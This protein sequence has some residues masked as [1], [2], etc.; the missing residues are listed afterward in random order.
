MY[1]M[2]LSAY[3]KVKLVD[4]TQPLIDHFFLICMYTTNFWIWYKSYRYWYAWI[5][6]K[7]MAGLTISISLNNFQ[8]KKHA[9]LFN[10]NLNQAWYTQF[11]INRSWEYYRKHVVNS[12][13]AFTHNQTRKNKKINDG[14][15]S[16]FF[17]YILYISI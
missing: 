10:L 7:K 16:L 5:I 2:Y 9:I 12:I 11:Y 3:V 13:Y 15:Y 6:S 4:Y 17:S 14:K 8:S 1:L